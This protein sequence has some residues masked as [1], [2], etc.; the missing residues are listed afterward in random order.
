MLEVPRHQFVPESLQKLAYADRP[1]PIGEEQTI[2]QPYI[3]AYMC[4]AL[5]LKGTERVLEVG[6]GSGYQTAIL[7]YLAKE[8]Y[9]VEISDLHFKEAQKKLASFNFK[10]VYFNLGDGLL[11]WPEQA[12]F[13]GILLSA[14]PDEAP[15]ALLDQLAVGGRAIIPLGGKSEQKLILF[16]KTSTEIRETFLFSVAFVLAKTGENIHED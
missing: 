6:T 10:N 14:S 12:P 9:T 8:V 11:G 3:V 1:L 7:A 5:Q 2:S 13:Q 15:Q 16:E 4:E